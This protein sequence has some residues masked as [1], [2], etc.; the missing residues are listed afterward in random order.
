ML[1]IWFDRLF[2]S[3]YKRLAVVEPYQASLVV[4][5][6]TAGFSLLALA[7]GGLNIG[8]GLLG[9]DPTDLAVN[10][11]L[12]AVGLLCLIAAAIFGYLLVRTVKETWL[13][14]LQQPGR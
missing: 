12:I 14:Q 8:M 2:W 4:F 9:W 1:S 10:L 11:V 6:V 13:R 5:L 3:W 7:L